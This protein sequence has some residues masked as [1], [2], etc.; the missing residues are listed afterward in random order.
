MTIQ[1][2]IQTIKIYQRLLC[3]KNK[4]NKHKCAGQ[5]ERQADSGTRDSSDWEDSPPTKDATPGT[6][7]RARRSSAFNVVTRVH[8]LVKNA[9]L[10]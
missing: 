4:K 8:Y 9:A 2:Y 3:S 1:L 5:A 7:T 6:S 10:L